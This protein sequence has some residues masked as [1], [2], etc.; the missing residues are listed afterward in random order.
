MQM[1]QSVCGCHC[2]LYHVAALASCPCASQPTNPAPVVVVVTSLLPGLIGEGLGSGCLT[3][4]EAFRPPPDPA[5][6][7]ACRADAALSPCLPCEAGWQASALCA[8]EPLPLCTTRCCY[9]ISP[10]GCVPPPLFLGVWF[11]CF[12]CYAL[13]VSSCKA[14][15]RA[16]CASELP[17]PYNP[18]GLYRC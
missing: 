9:V 8:A 1:T 6:H 7:D 15:A 16:W 18:S 10:W 4:V 17:C 12:C 5:L 14:T 11:A 13:G 3:L 2:A